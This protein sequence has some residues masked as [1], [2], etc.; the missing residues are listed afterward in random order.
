MEAPRR[1][2]LRGPFGPQPD[3]RGLGQRAGRSAPGVVG[4]DL[5]GGARSAGRAGHGRGGD[6]RLRAALQVGRRGAVTLAFEP[7]ALRPRG[8][9]CDAARESRPAFS[10]SG[11]HVHAGF[12]GP[13]AAGRGSGRRRRGP[14]DL[15]ADPG[16]DPR[17]RRGPGGRARR[18]GSGTV[19]TF[20]DGALGPRV[21]PGALGLGTSPPE[22]SSGLA[23]AAG[24]PPAAPVESP[25]G[26]SSR[27][28]S[29]PVTRPSSHS[30]PLEIACLSPER[31]S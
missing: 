17:V 16:R 27:A 3:S 7:V 21:P 10:G 24:L 1:L 4:G 15:A 8:A 2:P 20:P 13:S 12:D 23:G 5:A 22:L 18:G 26:R 25:A 28:T 30:R 14:V 29:S 31:P 6:R 19:T 11:R 9:V